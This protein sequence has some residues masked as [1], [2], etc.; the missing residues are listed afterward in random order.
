MLTILTSKSSDNV[1]DLFSVCESIQHALFKSVLFM[2]YATLFCCYVFLTVQCLRIPL[3]LYN[4]SKS[5]KHNSKP[6]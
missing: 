5:P 6:L 2:H 4:S 3:L 1:K